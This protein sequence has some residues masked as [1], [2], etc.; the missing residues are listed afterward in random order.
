MKNA[1][2][3]TEHERA[4]RIE[5][6]AAGADNFESA[7]E[8]QISLLELAVV[9]TFHR[10]R[11]LRTTLLVTL[12][13]IVVSF[14][15]PV[16]YTA[17]S[18][19]LPP[20]QSSSSGAAMLAQ[21]GGLNPLAS[22]ASSSL[23]MKN[24]NDLQVALLKSRTVEDAVITR[25]HLMDQFKVK[26]L[27]DARKKLEKVVDI[28]TETKDPL[29]R[30]S[31]EDRDPRR[32]TE[33]TNGYIDEF[34]KFSATLAVTEASQRRLFFEE[35][36]QQAKENLANAEE[37]LKAIE[38]KTG[39]IQLDSQ[40]RAAIQ[41]AAQLRAQVAAKEVQ[42]R[43]LRTYATGENSQVQ[44]AE[45]E[46]A[47]LRAQLDKMGAAAGGTAPALLPQGGMQQS[48]L[49]YARKLRDVKYFEAIFELLARQYEA[50][51]VDEA[52]QGAVVQVV[53]A[54]VIPDHHSSPKRTLIVIGAFA[55]GIFIGVLR[56]LSS[57]ALRRLSKNP[58]EEARLQLLRKT[59]SLRRQKAVSA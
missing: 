38:L 39:L 19:I 46:L 24:P 8:D 25:F 50:A 10:Y 44:I 18:S 7:G 15:L 13:A 12:L 53:D 56:A 40:A 41:S 21:L 42:I 23:G 59:L 31:I 9:F 51:K 5:P 6:P 47:G 4:E 27:S 1:T 28:E 14:L 16:R 29:I 3:L 33:L 35:Q 11:I 20:Q 49:D 30:V 17:T 37:N 58:A 43:A 32:A 55:L 52:R 36:L 34:K 57:E 22:L 54:A 26:Y 48:T 45:E 2:P